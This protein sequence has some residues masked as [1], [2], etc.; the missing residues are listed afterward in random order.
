VDFTLW[1]GEDEEKRCH[2]LKALSLPA[3]DTWM[4]S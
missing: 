2:C 4:H 1:K 3:H